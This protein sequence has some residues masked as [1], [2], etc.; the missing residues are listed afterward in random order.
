[1]KIT[2]EMRRAV[3]LEDCAKL[4]HEIRTDQAIQMF[5]VAPLTF[6]Q[7]VVNPTDQLPHL[8]CARCGTAWLV[9]PDEG[10]DYEDAER[11]LYGKLRADDV[12]ARKITRWRGERGKDKPRPGRPDEIVRPAEPEPG[13]GN[14]GK[15]NPNR[16]E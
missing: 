16:P 3:H 11:A 2:D 5:Q 9:V 13:K 7:G 4:G 15:G 10:A 6:H 8:Y 14:P 12:L 1:M